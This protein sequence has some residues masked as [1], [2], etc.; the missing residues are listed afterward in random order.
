MF[1]K[2]SKKVKSFQTERM[3]RE[4][5]TKENKGDHIKKVNLYPTISNI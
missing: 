1:K 5:K 4:L 3:K 2:Y